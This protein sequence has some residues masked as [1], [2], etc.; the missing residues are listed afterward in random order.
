MKQYLRVATL[1]CAICGRWAVSA[2]PLPGAPATNT[3]VF[4]K[5]SGEETGL[6]A[7]IGQWAAEELARQ[8]GK[9]K[10]HGWWLWGLTAIDLDN[11]GDPDLIPSHHG[12]SGGL[13]LQNR[14]KE[15]GQLIFTNVTKDLGLESRAIS[16]AI[17]RRTVA[18][19]MN[20]DGWL[21]FVGIRAPHYLN[22]DGK[23][24]APKGVK[25]FHTL[26]PISIEDVDG[27]GFPDIVQ[28]G[29]V[30]ILNPE[31][32]EF[33]SQPRPSPWDDKIPRS[34]MELVEEKRKSVRFWGHWYETDADLNNDGIDDVILCGFAGYFFNPMGR[35]FFAARDGALAD[36]T[37][38]SGLPPEATPIL[39]RDLTNNG[40]VDLLAAQSPSAGLYINDGQGRFRLQSGIVTDFL[41]ARGS[42]LH[43]ADVVDFDCDGDLDLVLYN[44]RATAVLVCENK[45]SGEFAEVFRTRGWDSDSVA[46]C[47]LNDDALPDLAIG[48]PGNSITLYVNESVGGNFG[49]VFVRMPKPNW[50][51]AGALVEAYEAGSLGKANVRPLLRAKAPADGTAIHIGLAKAR[52]YDLRVTYPGKERAV[53]SHKGLAANQRWIVTP[54]GKTEKQHQERQK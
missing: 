53:V 47:D 35:Y 29:N 30:Y 45:G 31:S 41:K 21:D 9:Y 5:L 16:Q 17:G 36:A 46:I 40:A 10:G 4:R 26:H 52:S 38:A 44:P 12:H 54:D 6:K 22:Q 3:V 32:C 15:T 34:I 13:I 48:G 43:R 50:T 37:A 1:C 25:G 39:L 27:D 28:R 2:E 42:Y 20:G 51:A 11:D 7:I 33:T 18:L 8:G 19:D 23:G 14:F 49:S 24:L